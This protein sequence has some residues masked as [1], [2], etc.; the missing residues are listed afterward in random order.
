MLVRGVTLEG[1][2][3]G[4]QFFIGSKSNWTKLAEVKVR[5]AT[6]SGAM[7]QV[8]AIRVKLCLF[9]VWND[10]AAQTFFTLSIGMGGIFTLSSYSEFHTNFFLDSVVMAFISYGRTGSP[11]L[12]L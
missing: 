4:I 7:R 8:G 2:G 1:A 10:A 5:E 9:Q 12:K 3:E 6:P 11:A